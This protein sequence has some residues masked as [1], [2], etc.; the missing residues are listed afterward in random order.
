M[1]GLGLHAYELA[2]YYP[3]PDHPR[4]GKSLADDNSESLA[5]FS[6]CSE[7]SD[8]H[9]VDGR[10]EDDVQRIVRDVLR[11]GHP[12]GVRFV[13]AARRENLDAVSLDELGFDDDAVALLLGADAS[14]RR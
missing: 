10:I 11:G 3:V 13:D 2:E 8:P 1:R 12:H 6:S 9:F 5:C 4:V 7:I 14:R